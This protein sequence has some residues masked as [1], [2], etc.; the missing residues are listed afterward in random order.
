MTGLRNTGRWLLCLSAF[1]VGGCM[2]ARVE[3]SRHTLTGIGDGDAVVVLAR[4][5]HNGNHTENDFIECL[6]RNLTVGPTPMRVIPQGRFRD[7]FYPWFEP[8]MAPKSPDELPRIMSEP[9]VA[10]RFRDS[11]L[12]YIIW[13]EGSTEALEGGGNISC[14]VG[15]GGGGCFGM[16]WWE[17]DSDYKAS[18]WDLHQLASAGQVATDVNGMSFMPAVIIPVPLVA[19]TQTTACKRL[20]DQLRLF[21]VEGPS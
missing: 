8:R 21:I 2:T 6:D 13:I 18:I 12:R 5:Y 17:K 14:S 3:Q 4:S 20:A 7:D 11:G 15:P 16:M 10:E 1:L 9:A 19:P